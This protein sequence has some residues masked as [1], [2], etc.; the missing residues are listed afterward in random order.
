MQKL[1]F[2][3]DDDKMILN[4]L[5]Y[6]IK[7][8]QDFDVMT[9][10][11]GEECLRNLNLNPDLIILDHVFKSDGVNT[12][13]GLDTLRKIRK[14]NTE[15]PVVILTSQEDE[16]L[17]KQFKDSGAS[18]FIPKNDYFIDVLMETISR[19]FYMEQSQIIIWN[20]S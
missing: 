13:N 11:S 15:I 5:E 18:G 6:T 20:K 19:K 17:K 14:V 1:V 12:L 16:S 4:L 10:Q 9:F 3:V 7:N 2:F 8:M